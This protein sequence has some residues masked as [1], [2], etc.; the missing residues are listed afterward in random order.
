MLDEYD[1]TLNDIYNKLNSGSYHTSR[2]VMEILMDNG[3][4]VTESTLVALMQGRVRMGDKNLQFKMKKSV[5][6]ESL[7]TL[8]AST[9]KPK[10]TEE[11]NSL[12]TSDSEML[13]A[14]R[15]LEVF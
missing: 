3:C 10:K 15:K 1:K 9:I 12:E 2:E 11:K 6:E 7:Y 13:E 14:I 4:L 8:V 5:G